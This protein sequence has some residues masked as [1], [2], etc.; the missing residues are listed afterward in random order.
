[1]SRSGYID[2]GNGW[3]LIRW[4]GAVASAIC[5]KR[6]QAF[7]VELVRSLDALPEKRLVG[8]SLVSNEGVCALGSVAVRRGLRVDDLDDGYDGEEVAER[9][10]IAEALAREIMHE[11]DEGRR[12]ET[13]EQRWIRIRDWAVARIRPESLLDDTEGGK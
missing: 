8:E 7:L 3:E 11:N 2:S 4:R 9:F 12:N 1:M 10:G 13:P 6:G 5:G